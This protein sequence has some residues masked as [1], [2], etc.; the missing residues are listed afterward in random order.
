MNAVEWL[1]RLSYNGSSQDPD[2]LYNSLFYTAAGE[3]NDAGGLFYAKSGLYTG[4]KIDIQFENGTNK[5]YNNTAAFKSNFD[6]VKDGET[7][8][9]KFCSGKPKGPGPPNRKRGVHMASPELEARAS[10]PNLRTNYPKAVNES[11]DGVIAGYFL[12]DDSSTAVLSITSFSPKLPT[13]TAYKEFSSVIS[14]FLVA[15]KKDGRSKL[16]ID[17]TSN[18]GGVIFLGYDLFKQVSRANL[19]PARGILT[20][21]LA[22]PGIQNIGRFQCTSHRAA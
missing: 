4:P 13:P 20:N 1:R 12:E 17:V 22:F 16:V 7:F 5:E 15:C 9:K 3:I 19:F 11:K 18:G 14:D 8:Y 10:M 21:L 6:G 2:A